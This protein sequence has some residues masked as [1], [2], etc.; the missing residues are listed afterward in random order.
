MHRYSRI[1]IFHN[2]SQIQSMML[3]KKACEEC[4]NLCISIIVA[5]S[6]Q[7]RTSLAKYTLAS[8]EN[9]PQGEYSCTYI[10][11]YLYVLVDRF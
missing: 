4:Q 8:N 10:F 1:L 3:L 7:E 11:M 6:E 2:K 5:S 9:A